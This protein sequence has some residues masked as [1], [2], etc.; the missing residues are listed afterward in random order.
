[1]WRKRK[2]YI[3]VENCFSG[4]KKGEIYNV[5][6]YPSDN[7]ETLRIHLQV[8]YDDEI[9]EIIPIHVDLLKKYFE[10]LDDTRLMKINKIKCYVA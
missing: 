5:Y 4:F 1:M 10:S 3:C 9:P 2:K 6:I 8:G 7:G